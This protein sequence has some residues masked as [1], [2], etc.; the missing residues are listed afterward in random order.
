MSD[1][2][3]ETTEAFKTSVVY[4]ILSPASLRFHDQINYRNFPAGLAGCA[5]VRG[6]D[7]K[8]KCATMSNSISS[9]GTIK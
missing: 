9:A 4:Q 2:A 1:V 8:Y 6:N 3:A 7:I 5:W